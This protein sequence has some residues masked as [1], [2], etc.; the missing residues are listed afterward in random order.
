MGE[1][2][3][4]LTLYGGIQAR[5]QESV[6]RI[7]EEK[8]RV[9]IREYVSEIATVSRQKDHLQRASMKVLCL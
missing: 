1:N 7:R 3:Y 9:N 6:K 4:I 5:K 8:T 2:A